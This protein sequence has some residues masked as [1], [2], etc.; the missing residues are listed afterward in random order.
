MRK[1]AKA[2]SFINEQKFYFWMLVFI[3]LA[4]SMQIYLQQFYPAPHP[5]RAGQKAVI[6]E[7]LPMQ[8]QQLE[9]SVNKIL[10]SKPVLGILLLTVSLSALLLFIG[11]I[12][13]GVMLFYQK[14]QGRSIVPFALEPTAGNWQIWDVFKVAIMVTAFAYV[15][16]IIIDNIVFFFLQEKAGAAILL[17]NAFLGEFLFVTFLIYV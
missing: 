13:I 11:G 17:W 15:I 14:M 10:Q 1:F 16:E 12:V 2:R 5:E 9:R 4:T 8:E 7:E 3:I 6:K